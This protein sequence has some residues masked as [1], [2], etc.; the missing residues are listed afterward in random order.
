[1]R[2]KPARRLSVWQNHRS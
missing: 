1:M 2:K